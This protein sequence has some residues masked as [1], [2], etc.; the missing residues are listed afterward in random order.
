MWPLCNFH[1]IIGQVDH[2]LLMTLLHFVFCVPFLFSFSFDCLS[3]LSLVIDNLAMP[4]ILCSIF[5]RLLVELIISDLVEPCILWSIPTTRYSCYYWWLALILYPGL[6]IEL[7]IDD[8]HVFNSHYKIYMLCIDHSYNCPINPLLSYYFLSVF[9]F[10]FLI[11]CVF[12]EEGGIGIMDSVKELYFPSLNLCVF[13][14][15]AGNWNNGFCAE[16]IFSPR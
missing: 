5:I 6:L 8:L 3:N 4:Y 1:S 15:Q 13:I 2:W 9:N 12:I 7:I 10:P 14:E 16:V 11:V